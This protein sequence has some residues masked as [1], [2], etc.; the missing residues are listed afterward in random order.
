MVLTI[1]AQIGGV[2]FFIFQYQMHVPMGS[3][4]SFHPPSQLFQEMLLRIIFYRMHRIES[5]SID[6]ILFKPIERIFNKKVTHNIAANVI[7]IDCCT[8]GSVV[9][10]G[11]K[12]LGIG[13]QIVAFWSEV[14]VN[15][16]QKHHQSFRV[17]GLH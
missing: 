5:Q 7:V 4:P 10:F 2:V 14:V 11:E 12:L 1:A 9:F 16:I 13:V 17:G 8:P 3:G 15:H 6:M